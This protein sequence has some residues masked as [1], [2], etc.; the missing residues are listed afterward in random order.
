MG[1]GLLGGGALL[2]PSFIYRAV[3]YIY[4]P[5]EYLGSKKHKKIKVFVYIYM[6]KVNFLEAFFINLEQKN[7]V[8]VVIDEAFVKVVSLVQSINKIK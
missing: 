6:L 5:N 7:Q 8:M 1:G 3:D 2:G 4:A